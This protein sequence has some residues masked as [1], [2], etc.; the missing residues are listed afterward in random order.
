MQN[1]QFMK[2][3]T[4]GVLLSGVALSACNPVRM[5]T[6]A[7]GLTEKEIGTGEKIHV[8]MP[9]EQALKALDEVAAQHGWAIVSVGDQYDM[10]GLRGKYYRLE[11]TRFIGG[12]KQMSG[13]FFIEPDGCFTVVGKHDSGLPT[14]LVEPF[15]AATH[16]QAGEVKLETQASETQ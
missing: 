13:V 8:K 7:V 14:E 16:G 4:F 10:Q 2:I 9:P 1:L 6:D 11:T 15:L 5:T 3:L 12:K